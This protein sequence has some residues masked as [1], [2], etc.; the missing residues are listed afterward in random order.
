MFHIIFGIL[1]ILL[2]ILDYYVIIFVDFQSELLA[3]IAA[4]LTIFVLFILSIS[5]ALKIIL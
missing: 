3:K 2:L 1:I 5:F 4:S